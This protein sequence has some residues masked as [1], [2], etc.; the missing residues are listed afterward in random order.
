MSAGINW[1]G[2][3]LVEQSGKKC[4]TGKNV[5]DLDESQVYI[6]IQKIVV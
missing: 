4:N 1:I 3:V 6:S 2:R 5:F